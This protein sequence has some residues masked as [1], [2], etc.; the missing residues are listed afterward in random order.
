[1][2]CSII[3]FLSKHFITGVPLYE[4]LR[5]R[6]TLAA[7]TVRLTRQGIPPVLRVARLRKGQTIFRRKGNLLAMKWKDSSDVKFL[8][9]AHTANMVDSGRQAQNGNNMKRCYLKYH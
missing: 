5:G 3:Y 9:T 1:M 7:G 2:M 8:T 4:E 6:G